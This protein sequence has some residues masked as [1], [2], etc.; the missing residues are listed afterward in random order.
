MPSAAAL[1]N[2]A[3][4]LVWL[5]TASMTTTRVAPAMTSPAVRSGRRPKDASAPRWT[6]KPVTAS[7]TAYDATCTGHCSAAT[8]GVRSASR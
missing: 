5:V 3:P 8:A 1:R 4:R 6:W 7:S 2:T